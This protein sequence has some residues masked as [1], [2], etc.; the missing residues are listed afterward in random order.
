MFW[1]K[2]QHA[3]V[4][5]SFILLFYITY[6]YTINLN[7]DLVSLTKTHSIILKQ[8]YHE[9]NGFKHSLNW[10]RERFLWLRIKDVDVHNFKMGPLK[11]AQSMP[12]CFPGPSTS[13]EYLL[14]ALH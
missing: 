3:I 1:V 11:S 4:K 13:R 7:S 14:N 2:C 12:V 10:H 5:M 6:R 8:K 9:K